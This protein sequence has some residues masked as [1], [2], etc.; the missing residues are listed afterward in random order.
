MHFRGTHIMFTVIVAVASVFPAQYASAIVFDDPFIQQWSF[1]DIGV[2]DA[3]EHTRG[4][5]D[6]IVAVID[7]EIVQYTQTLPISNINFIVIYA[8]PSNQPYN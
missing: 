3:W 8:C 7:N 5:H 1:E 4:S 6:V 2:Y